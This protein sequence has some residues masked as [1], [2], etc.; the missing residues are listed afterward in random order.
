MFYVTT[1][2]NVS[3]IFYGNILLF[4]QIQCFGNKFKILTTATVLKPNYKNIY[5][6]N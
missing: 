4:L 6:I 1:V 5:K 3:L 2:Q